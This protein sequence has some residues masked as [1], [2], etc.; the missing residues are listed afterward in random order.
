MDATRGYR[1]TVLTYPESGQLI[2]SLKQVPQDS[3]LRLLAYPD[4]PFLASL[5]HDLDDAVVKINIGWT[6]RRQLRQ[7]Q[8]GIQER[9]NDSP[10]ALAM[11]TVLPNHHKHPPY[12]L[13]AKRLD[14]L[15]RHPKRP[16]PHHGALLQDA[17]FDQP[18]EE[19]T[20]TPA[21]T[22]H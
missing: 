19:P 16:H 4:E 10:V 21:I 18:V 2:L 11:E 17:F 5:A 15:P 6:N 3:L 7:P 20:N 8:A 22:M 1:L 12:V 9:Q 14:D 13:G